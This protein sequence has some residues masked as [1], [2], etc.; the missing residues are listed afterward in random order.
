MLEKPQI[1]QLAMG[2]RPGLVVAKPLGRVDPDASDLVV[3]LT[4]PL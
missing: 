2:P 3:F 4:L 1:Q